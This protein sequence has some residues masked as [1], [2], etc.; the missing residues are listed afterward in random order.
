[1]TDLFALLYLIASYCSEGVVCGITITVGVSEESQMIEAKTAI[2]DIEG[3]P[4]LLNIESV[5]LPEKVH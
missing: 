3:V 5:V 2:N 4:Y 1:M